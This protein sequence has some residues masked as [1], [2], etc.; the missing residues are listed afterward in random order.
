M[1]GAWASAIGANP[2]AN[3]KVAND[4]KRSLAREALERLGTFKSFKSR[5]K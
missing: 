3:G 2:K 5:L 1:S 4:A